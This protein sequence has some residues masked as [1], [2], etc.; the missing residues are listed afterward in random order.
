MGWIGGP[1]VNTDT[2]KRISLLGWPAMV[3]GV[4][5][6]SMRTVDILLVG[7]VVGTVAVAGIGIADAV[8]RLVLRLAQGLGAGTVALVSQHLG[9]GRRHQ[10]DVA[11]T[12]A[13]ALGLMLG[14]PVGIAGWL[15]APAIFRLVGAPADVA[16][17][18]VGYLRIILLSAPFRM[19]AML[20][21]RALQAAEDTKTP[22]MVRVAATL[23]NVTL[24][25]LLV[26]GLGV[27][28]RL[29]A[30]GA[31]IGTAVG[32]VL[33]GTALVVVLAMGR[34][35]VGLV[36]A[37]W[38]APAVLRTTVRIGTPQVA[39]RL[40]YAVGELPLNAIVLVFGTE[41]N[42]A[43]Q[44]GRRVQQYLRMPAR[45]FAVAAGALVGGRLGAERMRSAD[46]HGRGAVELATLT[47][48]VLS[49]A[50][51]ASASVIPGWFVDDPMTIAIGSTWIRVLAVATVARAAY[52]VLR[53]SLQG[54]GDTRS[55]LLATVVGLTGFRLGFS[56][57]VGVLLF[58]RLGWVQL[59]VALDY[60]VRT[61]VLG[62]RYVRGRWMNIALTEPA[63]RSRAGHPPPADSKGSTPNP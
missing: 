51:I 2:W 34:S 24:T 57:L 58:R 19:L 43:F 46:H 38:W 21:S 20:G 47:T 13:V 41:A 26:P 32:N 44:I 50:A 37:G 39:E 7:R 15:L 59:G 8:A 54:A 42:A 25:V 33:S 17:V 53:G 23:V 61:A 60:A 49:A 52:S 10:A 28:P 45:G 14:I 12:Q 9:A 16:T 35:G 27:A 29:G 55:P 56:W 31:A 6:V 62:V 18:G 30:T 48:V 22:M 1:H 5:R 63:T 3:T 40:L 36:R 11:A 4:V